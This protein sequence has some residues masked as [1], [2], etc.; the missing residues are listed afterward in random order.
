MILKDAVKKVEE[1]KVFKAFIKEHS[2]YY[3]VHCFTMFDEGE[4]KHKWELGYYSQKTDKMV[5]FETDPKVNMKPEEE[6][7]KKEGTVKKLEISKV[8]ISPSSALEISTGLVKNKYPAQLI[9]KRIVILQNLDKQVYNITLISANFSILNI[10]IDSS[11]G[12]VL[13][14]NIQNIMSLGKRV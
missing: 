2:D 13:Q 1:S 12:E 4:R 7:F 6:A 3:L 14:D 5:V 10:R 11:T 9:T 8:K